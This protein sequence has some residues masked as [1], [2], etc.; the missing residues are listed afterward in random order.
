MESRKM[1]VQKNDDNT[2]TF[3]Q[4]DKIVG[5]YS[6]EGLKQEQKKLMGILLEIQKKI[7]LIEEL[8]AR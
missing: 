2:Y 6:Y 4:H 3:Y 5:T 7:E 8:E 1:K